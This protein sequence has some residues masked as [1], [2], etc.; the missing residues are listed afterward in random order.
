MSQ[1]EKLLS[2]KGKS[3]ILHGGH[4]YTVERGTTTK[5]IFRCQNRDCKGKLASNINQL[6]QMK[7]IF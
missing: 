5:L 3:M 1:I 2:V 7:I 6:V 4:I